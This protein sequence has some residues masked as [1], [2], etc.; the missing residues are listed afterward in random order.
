MGEYVIQT[1]TPNVH[2]APRNKLHWAMSGWPVILKLDAPISLLIANS[3]YIKVVSQS[4]TVVEDKNNQWATFS[5]CVSVQT[6]KIFQSYFFW[7]DTK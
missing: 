5:V 4:H 7:H 1:L 3:Q 6:L 2:P